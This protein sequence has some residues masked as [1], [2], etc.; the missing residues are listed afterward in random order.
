MLASADAAAG[1]ADTKKLGC[2]A[3]NTF[4]EGGNARLGPNLYGVVGALHGPMAGFDYTSGLK[5]KPGP[6][7]YD[8]LN[9]WLKRSAYAPGSRMTSAGISKPKERA[10]VSAYLWTRS[11]TP[12]PVPGK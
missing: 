2:T 12:E 1:K 7:T 10:D 9:E 3:C 4:N 11:P 5:S 8:E 6:S